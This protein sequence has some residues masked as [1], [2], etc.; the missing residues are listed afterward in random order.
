MSSL[1]YTKY[2]YAFGSISRLSIPFSPPACLLMSTAT[3][4]KHPV[5]RST[6]RGIWSAAAP[7]ALLHDLP[8]ISQPELSNEFAQFQKALC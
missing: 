6:R 5:A 2:P 1:S 8:V 3:Q 4:C 7:T